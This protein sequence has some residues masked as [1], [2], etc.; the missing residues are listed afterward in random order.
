MSVFPL[1]MP[2]RQT[3]ALVIVPYIG[4]LYWL[5]PI[6]APLHPENHNC[7]RLL[8]ATPT[9]P[10]TF[11]KSRHSRYTLAPPFTCSPAWGRR[12][13]GRKVALN[14]RVCVPFYLALISITHKISARAWTVS[15][16]PIT[17][18]ECQFPD[19]PSPLISRSCKQFSKRS[20]V[21]S[22]PS[23]QLATLP[24]STFVLTTETCVM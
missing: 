2:L 16:L 7:A 18:T 22:P 1:R 24:A 14:K 20:I 21:L 5:S 3:N 6:S 13:W 11:T 17:Y 15:M 19:P 8:L 4:F 9:H 10:S 23:V 12:F